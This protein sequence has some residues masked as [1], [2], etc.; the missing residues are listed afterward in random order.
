VIG[1]TLALHG[2]DKRWQ[3]TVEDCVRQIVSV[4]LESPAERFSLREVPMQSRI[5]EMEF[6]F[7]LKQLSSEALT[8]YLQRHAGSMAGN[9]LEG[10]SPKLVFAPTRG[11]MK[12]FVDLVFY[13]HRRWYLI[14]WKSNHLGETVLS[15]HPDRLKTVMVENHYVLQYLI[16]TLAVHLHL[17]RRA[18]GYEYERDFG[19][20]FYMFIRGIDSGRNVPYGI[21][22]DKPPLER[23]QELARRLIPGDAARDARTNE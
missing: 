22:M 3:N 9:V 8:E 15:Y 17:R 11:Y 7:P 19:G 20:V 16:Y 21:F 10:F 18:P 4:R 6:Y 2:F 14:D 13:H 12:G 5:N 23:I 1:S